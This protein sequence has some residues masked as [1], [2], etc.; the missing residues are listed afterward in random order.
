MDVVNW[1]DECPG[2]IN[3]GRANTVR[4]LPRE[5]LAKSVMA[6]LRDQCT[7]FSYIK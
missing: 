1:H 4:E 7:L 3:V 2:Y 6:I 5:K